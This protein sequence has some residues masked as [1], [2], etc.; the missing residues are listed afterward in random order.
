MEYLRQC[1]LDTHVLLW[2]LNGDKVSKAVHDVLS[3]GDCHVYVS[4][5]SA[6]ELATKHRLG[7]LPQAADVVAVYHE[8]LFEQGFSHLSVTTQHALM[9]GAF[10]QPHGDPFDRLLAAQ[11]LCDDLPVLSRDP[12][13][14]AFG[15]RRIW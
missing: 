6:L 12:A 2:W 13:L 15:I 3:Y 4:S 11:S 7:K 5:I 14:D 8:R 10:P 9:A 1:L